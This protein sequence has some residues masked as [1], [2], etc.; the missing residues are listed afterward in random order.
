[1]KRRIHL[2]AAAVFLFAAPVEAQQSA[3]G[4]ASHAAFARLDFWVGE[5]DVF[6]GTQKDGDNVITKI[7]SG[8]AITE[9]WSAQGGGTGRSLFYVVPPDLRWRQV[10]VTGVALAPGGVKEKR[11]VEVSSGAIRFQGTVS[12]TAGRSWLDR[13]TLTPNPDGSVRQHIEISTDNGTT[14]RTTF[15]AVYRRRR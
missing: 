12:D 14:W 13:T 9:N 5:W 11:E 4:C 10:W 15:D 3:A 1:V 6:V 7:E 8:C 2:W